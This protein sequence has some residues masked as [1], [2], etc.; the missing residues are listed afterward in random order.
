MAAI[1]QLTIPLSFTVLQIKLV[2]LGAIRITIGV[3]NGKDHREIIVG[4][5]L[6][7][8]DPQIQVIRG[9]LFDIDGVFHK[10][11]TFPVVIV[12]TALQEHVL[13][14]LLPATAKR[15]EKTTEN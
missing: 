13:L 14:S 4:I 10:V 2:S 3:K 11:E 9:L 8:T 5:I 7:K 15:K 12:K 1:T 6:G